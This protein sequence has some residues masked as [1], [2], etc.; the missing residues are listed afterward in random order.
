M[1]VLTMAQ[2]ESVRPLCFRWKAVRWEYRSAGKWRSGSGRRV[3]IG[4]VRGPIDQV[5]MQAI[6]P[7]ADEDAFVRQRDARIGGV[8][9]VGQKTPFQTAAPCALC[10]SCT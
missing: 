10:T 6:L 4:F 5:Q 7:F 2:P 3:G 8:G 1:P 9:D